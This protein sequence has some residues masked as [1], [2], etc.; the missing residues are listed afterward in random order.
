[1]SPMIYRLALD[2]LVGWIHQDPLRVGGAWCLGG[3]EE[4]IAIYDDVLLHLSW[5]TLSID[6]ALHTFMIF[7]EHARYH[8]NWDKSCVHLLAVGTT[9]LPPGYTGDG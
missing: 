8:I 7:G 1:M 9:A 6:R 5:P 2:P 4:A 3:G